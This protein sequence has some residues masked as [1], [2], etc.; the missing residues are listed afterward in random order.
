M[1]DLFAQPND[2]ALIPELCLSMISGVHANLLTI[3][4]IVELLPLEEVM[5]LF[6]RSASISGAARS[7]HQTP[8]RGRYH[9]ATLVRV[10]LALLS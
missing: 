2:L 3:E 8:C 4:V 9:F 5:D 10:I 1:A 7:A 6:W